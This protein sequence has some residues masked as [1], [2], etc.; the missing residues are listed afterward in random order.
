M[1]VKSK[2]NCR[3]GSELRKKLERRPVFEALDRRELMAAHYIDVRDIGGPG[4]VPLV[5]DFN[6][7]GKADIG[8][9]IPRTAQGD[10]RWVVKLNQGNGTFR[11]EYYI[12]RRDIGGVGELP[13]VGDFN[14]DG[15]ADIGVYIPRTAQGNSRWVVKL[16][17]GNGTFAN[18]YYIDV[19][20]IGGVGELPLVGDF[21]GDRKAD[22]GVYIPRTAQ[23]DCRW[24]VKLNQG[25]GTFGSK[26]YIDR[27][28]IGGPGEAP[29]VGD[30]NGDGKADIG[31]YI[32]RTPEGNSRWVAKFNQGNGQFGSR[33]DIDYPDIGG[34][35]ELPLVGN[36]DGDRL[37]DIG[38]YIPRTAQGD[39][40]WVV[41]EDCMSRQARLLTSELFVTALK[42]SKQFGDW[43]RDLSWAEDRLL[44]R[45][46]ARMQTVLED[47][48]AEMSSKSPEQIG[49]W[50]A[51]IL[52]RTPYKA[53]GDAD[54]VWARNRA[55]F[56]GF[57]AHV[58]PS[59]R[60]AL[61]KVFDSKAFKADFRT[62]IADGVILY[63]P[64]TGRVVVQ[65][66]DRG[67]TVTIAA[68]Q[69]GS[70]A[71]S[72]TNS[73]LAIN[74]YF[75][76][77]VTEVEIWAKGG[78]DSVRNSTQ[79]PS[80]MHGGAGR[81]ELE[82]TAGI[83]VFD[84]GAGR[85]QLNVTLDLEEVLEHPD[86]LSAVASAVGDTV[87]LSLDLGPIWTEIVQPS[88]ERCAEVLRPLV[89]PLSDL[90]DTT[91]IDIGEFGWEVTVNDFLSTL[92]VSDQIVGIVNWAQGIIDADASLDVGGVIDVGEFTLSAEP[93]R[94]S[95]LDAL[96][97]AVADAIDDLERCGLTFP[98]LT[99]PNVLVGLLF[100][101]D[102]DLFRCQFEASLNKTERLAD[103]WV[104][105]FGVPVQWWVK[106]G[107]AG[108][109]AISA[110]MDTSGI[111][112]GDMLDGLFVE[113]A[114]DLKLSL[115]A[116]GGYEGEID[117]VGV[118]GEVSLNGEVAAA[119]DFVLGNCDPGARCYFARGGSGIPDV[120]VGITGSGSVY[121]KGRAKLF[122]ETIFDERYTFWADEISI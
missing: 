100:G 16:N 110:G 23:G 115:T 50:Y 12:D 97:A 119:F 85:D 61:A 121:A 54:Y 66:T 38:V 67:D 79:V 83:D 48:M 33:C 116:S 39:T 43:D 73:V 64:A 113:L 71:V 3:L 7:D 75:P 47:A 117:C 46:Y 82:G 93:L 92:G 57:W 24:V 20:D 98:V 29:L 108:H 18:R 40:R 2:K 45:E 62:A 106:G 70:V 87:R 51:D 105:V 42:G 84:G 78:N 59:V 26:Y 37:A 96:P 104:T 72:M 88:V 109:I 6:G 101:E 94:G 103:G 53:A 32:A 8:V 86:R 102:V 63:Y 25:N 60:E 111:R 77:G 44:N 22:I 99:D 28:D 5:G 4:E 65:G 91:L 55:S 27:R 34:D 114:A 90:L 21:N 30:F 9:Y 95:I 68:P 35:G 122:G 56:Q 52:A 80:T 112:R 76:K 69:P 14:G 58:A 49:R 74:Q 31:V 10:C 81:D 120:D 15:K 41:E 17:Q 89:Q 107:I 11:S 19:R 118:E 36:F 1:S 13:L